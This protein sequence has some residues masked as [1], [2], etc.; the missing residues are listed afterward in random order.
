MYVAQANDNTV[1][2]IDGAAC[3]AKTSTG[4]AQRPPTVTVAGGPDGLGVDETTGTVF[5]SNN[6]PG[7]TVSSASVS[8]IDGT[9]CNGNTTTG[10]GQSL[11]TALTGANPG[12][13][14]VDPATGTF[15][16]PAL[17][18]KVL[19]TIN[20]ATCN[21]TV[22]TGGGRPLRPRRRVSTRSPS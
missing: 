2:V 18:D 6:S 20:S 10:C 14:A 16:V 19:A 1:S 17:G 13:P 9:T 22:R 5:A 8:V 11:P 4:C 7:S 15:Y 12:F 3:S 21:A